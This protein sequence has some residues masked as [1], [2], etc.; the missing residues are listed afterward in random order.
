MLKLFIYKYT[1]KNYKL[2]PF[3]SKYRKSIIRMSKNQ[4]FINKNIETEYVVYHLFNKLFGITN[5]EFETV[6]VGRPII[7]DNPFHFNIAHS[8]DYLVVAISDKNISVDIEHINPKRLK[9][10]KKIYKEKVDY[11]IERVIKDFTIKEAF[12]KYFA[13]TAT[14]N[15]K[16]IVFD[17]ETVNNGKYS[18][19]Y[20]SFTY[21]NEYQIS[22]CT[23]IN[24]VF[25]LEIIESVDKLFDL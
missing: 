7:K 5:L 1:N 25:D 3:F 4:D 21:L 22:L 24:N 16:E 6:G 17:E 13:G 20:Q 18:L 10:K 19:Y 14:S 12:V 8:K 9:I 23:T 2:Q 15:L 11:D